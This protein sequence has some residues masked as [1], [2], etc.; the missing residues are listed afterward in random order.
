M[1]DQSTSPQ[2]VPQAWT[3]LDKT[4]PGCRFKNHK[5]VLQCK[6]CGYDFRGPPVAEG[7]P[8]T[9]EP[10]LFRAAFGSP[11][12]S[13]PASNRS[14]AN[15]FIAFALI[16]SLSVAAVTVFLVRT[17]HSTITRAPSAAN[18][19]SGGTF[20]QPTGAGQ[21][22]IALS[23]NPGKATRYRLTLQMKATASAAGRSQR[24]D[25]T[26]SEDLSWTVLS[27]DRHGTASVQIIGSN[28]RVRM[29]GRTQRI[30]VPAQYFEITPQ[31]QI[32][33][34]GEELFTGVS[35]GQVAMGSEGLSA[36]L[37]D[38]NARPGESWTK[39][40]VVT[41]FGSPVAYTARSAYLRTGR[42]GS[43]M[44]AIVQTSAAVPM[45]LAVRL[46]R[47]STLFGIQGRVSRKTVL[48]QV[49]RVGELRTSWIDMQSK[50]L[51]KTTTVSHVAVRMWVSGA[52]AGR[53][54]PA[55]TVHGTL[56]MTLRRR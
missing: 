13:H 6:R 53:S 15:L 37:P 25:F 40:V 34:G 36:I 41:M 28:V 50:D 12:P 8:S 5:M 10:A 3:E 49:G 32:L 55:I 19:P 26:V 16:G 14:L 54:I 47:Y 22:A 31:G 27:I 35:G 43:R 20:A 2:P 38:R 42:L 48:H 23:F 18:A 29:D 45:R 51:L 1:S 9:S 30:D 11:A 56:S 24:L 46:A 44:A 39:R 7:A 52:P 21:N 33:S 4:C 17:R